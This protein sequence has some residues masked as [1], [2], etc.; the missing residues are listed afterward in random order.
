M[1]IKH[2]DVKA[3][4]EK[5]FASEWN[6]NHVVDDDVDMVQNQLLNNVVENRTDMPAGPVEGQMIYRT[7][8][9]TLF[10]FNGASWVRHEGSPIG[11]I[12]AWLKTFTNTPALPFGWVECNGQVLSDADSVYDGQT[13]P[14]LN[15]TNN[16]LRGNATSGGT[17]GTASSAHSHSLTPTGAYNI[18]LTGAHFLMEQVASTTGVPDDFTTNSA[19]SGTGN[20]P[21]YYNVVWIMRVK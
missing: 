7:D 15:A 16:F 17:G 6:K 2:S 20:L 10:I 19:G 12:V 4:G 3:S 18:T 1:G 5:G 14:S 21:P 13:L 8:L 11:A 9:N